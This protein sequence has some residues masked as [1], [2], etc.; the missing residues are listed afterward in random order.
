MV[1]R[2]GESRLAEVATTLTHGE[3]EVIEVR[4]ARRVGP[5]AVARKLRRVAGAGGDISGARASMADLTT[6]A[7]TENEAAAKQRA[8]SIRDE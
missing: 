2:E 4:G 8:C 5:M 3:D 7:E 6:Q 1:A